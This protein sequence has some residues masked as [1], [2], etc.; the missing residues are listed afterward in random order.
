MLG[1]DIT[2]SCHDTA[3]FLYRDDVAREVFLVAIETATKRGQVMQRVWPWVRNFM[4]RQSVFMS[5]HSLVKARSFYVMTEYFCVTTK[6]GQ[7]Q[8]N[9]CRDKIFL[10]RDR[11][12]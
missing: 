12:G 11:V 3:L 1:H 9:L 10:C 6:F 2:L 8:K 5:R 7:D 4:S